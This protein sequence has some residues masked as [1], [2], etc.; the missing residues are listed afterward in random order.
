MEKERRIEKL[1]RAF[2]KKR[3]ADAGA[4]LEL[5]P[6]NRRLLHEEIA[7]RTPATQREQKMWWQIL[8]ATPQRAF[9][10]C[11][12]ASLVISGVLVLVVSLETKPQKT[13]ALAGN[14]LEKTEIAN[15]PPSAQPPSPLS[16]V[17]PPVESPA[18]AVMERARDRD[19]NLR[20]ASRE[21]FQTLSEIGKT[22]GFGNAASFAVD[23]SSDSSA[24][25]ALRK[26]TPAGTQMNEATLIGPQE[27]IA[28]NLEALS[29]SA[30]LGYAEAPSAS[31]AASPVYFADGG[32][33]RFENVD[34]A[35]LSQRFYR[36]RLPATSVVTKRKAK[37]AVLD[38]FTVQQKGDQIV[39]VDSDGSHYSG[40]VQL[41]PLREEDLSDVGRAA[42]SKDMVETA[43][44]LRSAPVAAG[45]VNQIA[46]PARRQAS[47][48]SFFFRVS[49][50]NENSQQRVVFS[51]NFLVPTNGNRGASSAVRLTNG[52]DAVMF[53]LKPVQDN[54]LQNARIEG[55]VTVSGESAIEIKALPAAP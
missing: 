11:A 6:A 46:Q 48:Q 43:P 21:D 10:T 18:P 55:R 34:K 50:T 2:A 27:T 4:P 41:A 19:T 5:H 51:G 13:I 14:R 12:M 52:T 29:N 17:A 7:R 33:Q 45:V 22:N 47:T 32:E 36:L 16:A 26:I 42:A 24:L 31:P 28:Q 3:K 44:S 23:N 15:E 35:V 37:P 1:L 53:D 25:D 20:R 39:V 49:G 54:F 8:F 38:S 30:V 40:F 9:A